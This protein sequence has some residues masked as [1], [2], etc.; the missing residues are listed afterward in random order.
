MKRKRIALLVACLF[1]NAACAAEDSSG[2]KSSEADYFQE[3]PV[4]LSASRL[5]QPL[6][7][8]PNAMTVIDRKMID[9]SGFRSIADLFKL[10]PGMYVSYFKG[11]EPIVSYHGTTD[12]YAR[13]M[14]VMIDGRSVYMPPNNMVDWYTLPITMDDIERVEVVRGPA[15]ASYGANST[16][17]VINIITRD[18]G[19]VDGAN[20]SY[21]HDN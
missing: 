16:Q 12:P 3:F 15:A 20:L 1:W 13:R 8:A 6:S 4:V 14:Q 17:G 5:S 19:A 18:A 9:A 2:G 7:E 10:V 11:S 21:T